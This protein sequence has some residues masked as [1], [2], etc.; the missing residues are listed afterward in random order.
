[1]VSELDGTLHLV[2][3]FYGFLRARPLS[4]GEQ[5]GVRTQLSPELA[6]LF[7]A[8]PAPDQRHAV[9]VARRVSQ[10]L[11]GDAAAN[12]A[13]LMHDVGKRHSGL[14]AIGRSL[15]TVYDT[16]GLP[17]TSRMRS[18][19]DHGAVGADEVAAAGA[20]AFTIVFT[21]SH[22]G[23]VPT[24]VDEQRWQALAAADEA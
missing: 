16:A 19:R 9:E 24:G 21:R 3:R 22:P 20:T 14:G 18:Y 13:A 15:A 10:L 4:P 8:Q 2:R 1:V 11:P 23:P 17:L 7:F 12:E 6:M 5:D